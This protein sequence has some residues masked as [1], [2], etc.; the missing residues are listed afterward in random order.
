MT[1]ETLAGYGFAVVAN[2]WID[3]RRFIIEPVDHG[4]MALTG[5][6]YAFLIGDEIV[7]FG[8][9]KAVLANRFR[10]WQRDVTGSLAEKVT[11]TPEWEAALWLEKLPP[12]VTGTVWARVG[13]TVTTPAGTFNAYMAEES[14]LIGK[15]LPVL[16]R[17][18]HR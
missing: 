15:H 5:S 9:S 18:K 10:T 11:S 17:S 13:T 6:V 14:F 16:N 7:R 1:A 2:L 12:G 3:E 8:S 4:A